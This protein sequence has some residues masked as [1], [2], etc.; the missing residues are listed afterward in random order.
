[1]SNA[2]MSS[3]SVT[4]LYDGKPQKKPH[5]CDIFMF[6]PIV[7]FKVENILTGSTSDSFTSTG[8]CLTLIL[9]NNSKQIYG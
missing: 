6:G 9:A 8:K 5:R 4:G 7:C 3:A 1:M 2:H